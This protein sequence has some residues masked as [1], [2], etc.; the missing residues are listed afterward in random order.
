MNVPLPKHRWQENYSA[1]LMNNQLQ[2]L[3]D[4]SL[5]IPREIP[6]NLQ[7]KETKDQAMKLT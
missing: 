5:G 3:Q 4:H 1:I 7:N 6:A 2:N